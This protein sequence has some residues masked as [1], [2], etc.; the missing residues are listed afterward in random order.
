M[1]RTSRLAVLLAIAFWLCAAPA[2]S[3]GAKP[4]WEEF[5]HPSGF[6]F[7]LPD[8]WKVGAEGDNLSGEDKKGLAAIEVYVPKNIRQFDRAV[9]DL[10]KELNETM[11]NMRFDKPATSRV[12]V[13]DRTF[14]TGTGVDRKEGVEMEFSIGIYAKNGK[15][16]IAFAVTASDYFDDYEGVF[17][18]ILN[19]VK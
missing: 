10:G 3:V 18:K 14:I 12:G 7:W 17:E 4:A 1:Q 11:K 9:D 15:L 8:D 6:K 2:A 19:S 13:V 5:T 16:L